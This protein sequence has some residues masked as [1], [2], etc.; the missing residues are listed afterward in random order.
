[1]YPCIIPTIVKDYNRMR[2]NYKRIFDCLPVSKMIF[3]GPADLE[4]IVEEDR[5][6]KV[7]DDHNVEYINENDIMSLAS[8]K[9]TFNSLITPENNLK[10]TAV[11]WYYQQFLKMGYSRICDADYYLCWDADTVPLRKIELFSEDGKP[12]LDVKPEYNNTYFI[13]IERLFGF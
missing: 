9:P 2:T 1:M 5:K 6:N 12:Y 10:P 13:T 7:F 11:N 3:I 4:G 8:L